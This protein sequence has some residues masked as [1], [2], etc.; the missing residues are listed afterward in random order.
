[1]FKSFLLLVFTALA[2]CA[3]FAEGDFRY[4]DLPPEIRTHI[5][6]IRASCKEGMP[7]FRPYSEMDGVTILDLDGNG[8]QDVMVDNEWLCEGSQHG[9]NCTNRGC[10]LKIWKQVAPQRWQ[11]IFDDHL[12]RK[13][14]SVTDDGRLAAIAASIWA[15]SKECHPPRGKE[16]TS[17]VSCDV[18]IH[19]RGGRWRYDRIN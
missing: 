9:Y 3:A 17:G 4:Q 15:G 14:I 5:E 2:A 7:E 12:Y 6:G 8:H 19:Y 18:L 1:M 13:F 16:F 10:D 11:K